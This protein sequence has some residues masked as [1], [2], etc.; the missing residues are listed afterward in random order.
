MYV[1][2]SAIV[3]KAIYTPGDLS[4]KK[5]PSTKISMFDMGLGDDIE[6]KFPGEV[7]LKAG[8]PIN[9]EGEFSISKFQNYTT[10]QAVEGQ[11][12]LQN[13]GRIVY[14]TPG[15]KEVKTQ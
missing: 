12:S 14:D 6:L 3:K 10:I 15:Q 4:T 2:V 13:A 5:K 8:T 7:V 1:K 11:Y 9:I